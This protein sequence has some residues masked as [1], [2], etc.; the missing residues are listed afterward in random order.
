VEQPAR[1]YLVI[2]RNCEH[3]AHH[4]TGL[5]AAADEVID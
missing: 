3:V 5:L 1:L 4:G 2:N